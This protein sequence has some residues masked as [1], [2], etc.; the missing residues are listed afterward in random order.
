MGRAMSH[1]KWEALSSNVKGARRRLKKGVDDVGAKLNEGRKSDLR[2]T[3]DRINAMRSAD[4]TPE[5]AAERNARRRE[6]YAA[7][8]VGKWQSDIL[9][10]GE[11]GSGDG[12]PYKL[13]GVWFDPEDRN[14]VFRA[15]DWC[16]D[17]IR[18]KPVE[19]ALVMT[20]DGDI[21]H[22]MGTV[23]AVDL[24]GVPLDGATVVHN[25]PE[26]AGGGSF[27]G[28]GFKF[29]RDHPELHELWAVTEQYDYRVRQLAPF[30]VDYGVAYSH[31][32]VDEIDDDYKHLVMEWLHEQG[33]IDYRR[34]P[35]SPKS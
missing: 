21:W 26:E 22:S 25:H 34:L 35:V 29:L 2:S 18:D 3:K 31:V 19:N 32:A 17:A 23:D 27:G 15:L 16:K 8:K 13:K 28:D 12:E 10:A 14:Q 11:G 33:Y 4:Y 1:K 30:G 24:S 20:A 6:L 9:G 7:Q 5:K